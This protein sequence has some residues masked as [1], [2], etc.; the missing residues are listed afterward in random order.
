[1]AAGR[2]EPLE[3]PEEPDSGPSSI[4]DENIENTIVDD[5]LA[6]VKFTDRDRE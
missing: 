3:R 6:E 1:M 2:E 4:A 5:V